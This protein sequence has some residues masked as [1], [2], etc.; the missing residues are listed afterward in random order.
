MGRTSLGARAPLREISIGWATVACH[1]PSISD[2]L[3]TPAR[4][5]GSNSRDRSADLH[6]VSWDK[7]GWRYI[8]TVFFELSYTCLSIL[9]RV[10]DSNQIFSSGFFTQLQFSDLE[11]LLHA[12]V[13]SPTK[14]LATVICILLSDRSFVGFFFISL[15]SE[16]AIRVPKTSISMSVSRI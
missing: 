9:C 11:N 14:F 3:R 8:F 4:T 10:V 15:R 7:N 5:T 16:S 12:G 1:R 2:T 13:R 6:R